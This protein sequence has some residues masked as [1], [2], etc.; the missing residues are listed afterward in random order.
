MSLVVVGLILVMI[1]VYRSYPPKFDSRF[2]WNVGPMSTAL[3]AIVGA[4]W[5]FG[6]LKFL[7]ASLDKTMET[8]SGFLPILVLLMPLIGF[9]GP[10]THY[11]E[12]DIIHNL[13]GPLGYLWALLAGFF[14]PG[15]SSLGGVVAHLWRVKHE[16]R[17]VL[18][19]L[20]TVTPLNS[21]TIFYIRRLGLGDDIASEMYRVNWAIA[22]GLMP[23]FW[24][25]GRFFYR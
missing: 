12:R 15:G 2:W 10:L 24:A 6:G 18:L 11:L 8:A 16:L 25:Y 5:H 1:G 9:S 21:L 14:S 13:M 4:S 22:I 17:P 3:V 7:A 20:L 23:F 19:Y